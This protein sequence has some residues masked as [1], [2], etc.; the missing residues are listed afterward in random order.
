MKKKGLTLLVAILFLSVLALTA[1]FLFRESPLPPEKTLEMPIN[2]RTEREHFHEP[3]A[4]PQTVSDPVMGYC[5]NT[6]TTVHFSNGKKHSFMFGN[7]VS[8]TDFLM[9]LKYDPQ[10]TCSCLFE[11]KVDTEFESGYEISLTKSFVRSTSGQAD[12][13]LEQIETLKDIFSQV[14]KEMEERK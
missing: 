6:M 8:L 14:E 1:A 3:C 11:Y 13:T 9:H 2:A 7:S 10:K 12:L 5:G 4:L